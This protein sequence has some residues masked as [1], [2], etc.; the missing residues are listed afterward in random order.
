LLKAAASSGVLLVAAW[1]AWGSRREPEIR[2][3]EPEFHF[4]LDRDANVNGSVQLRVHNDGDVPLRVSGSQDSYRLHVFAEVEGGLV[5]FGNPLYA[6]WAAPGR[7]EL[8][9]GAS[10]LLSAQGQVARPDAPLRVRFA[11]HRWPPEPWWRK[12]AAAGFRHA[13][14]GA[15]LDAW[16]LRN[17]LTA[18]PRLIHSPWYEVEVPDLDPFT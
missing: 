10:G 3:G 4:S 7:L 9:P 16:I 8:L 2:F 14:L 12:L 15:A 13:R 17:L 18:P 11:V 1:M 6:C 5:V